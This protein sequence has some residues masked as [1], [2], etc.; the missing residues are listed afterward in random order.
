VSTYCPYDIETDPATF[1]LTGDVIDTRFGD[2]FVVRSPERTAD[3]AT[4]F[5]HGVGSSWT[6]WT[7]L[8]R[9]ALERGQLPG[10][11]ILVDL[12]GFGRSENTLD[13]LNSL[14]VAACLG[15]IIKDYGYGRARL[16]GHSMG[17]LLALDMAA[18]PQLE[19]SSLHLASGAAFAIVDAVNNPFASLFRTPAADILF[20]SQY[21]LALTGGGQRLAGLSNR[22]H[23]LSP[24]LRGLLAHPSRIR[25]SVLD[26]L[27]TELRPR[28]FRHAAR[29]IFGYDAQERWCS[30]GCPVYTAFGGR[31]WLVP[32][33][34]RVTL[35]TVYP[36]AR[37]TVIDD[38]AHFLHIERPHS[39]LTALGL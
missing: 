13:H 15:E 14:Q 12:P 37:I 16:V 24:A 6:T 23:L 7:P 26:A 11:L 17:G 19:I 8:L 5:L 9:A 27:V 22:L 29:N 39:A 10:D 20:W 30:L 36:N 32:A 28:S 3:Q 33:R 38:A 1:G 4:F 35:A 31:D 21:A 25:A 18:R 34:D 2:M